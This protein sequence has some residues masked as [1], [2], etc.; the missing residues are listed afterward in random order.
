MSF[1][2]PEETTRQSAKEER[3][4]RDFVGEKK[5]KEI[6]MSSSLVDAAKTHYDRIQFARECDRTFREATGAAKNATARAMESA[7]GLV[8]GGGGRPVV[9]SGAGEEKSASTS[10]GRQREKDIFYRAKACERFDDLGGRGGL[11]QC[12]VVQPAHEENVLCVVDGKGRTMWKEEMSERHAERRGEDGKLRAGEVVDVGAY[13][14]R[15]TSEGEEDGPFEYS[16]DGEGKTTSSEYGSGESSSCFSSSDNDED[17]NR[18]KR[19]PPPPPEMVVELKVNEKSGRIQPPPGY[20]LVAKPEYDEF[21]IAIEHPGVEYEKQNWWQYFWGYAKVPKP[22]EVT[23]KQKGSGVLSSPK[24]SRRKNTPTAVAQ[25][26]KEK[27]DTETKI[28]KEKKEKTKWMR[29][30]WPGKSEGKPRPRPFTDEEVEQAR[31]ELLSKEAEA[32][33]TAA[34]LDTRAKLEAAKAAEAALEASKAALKV[35]E[36]ALANAKVQEA[37]MRAEQ[38][39][40]AVMMA[41][42][43]ERLAKVALVSTLPTHKDYDNAKYATRNVNL[44]TKEEFERLYG[45]EVNATNYPVLEAY[46]KAYEHQRLNTPS[47]ST[48]APYHTPEM[49]VSAATNNNVNNNNNNNKNNKN[50]NNAI[51]DSLKWLAKGGPLQQS[52]REHE[53]QKPNVTLPKVDPAVFMPVAHEFQKFMPP[54]AAVPVSTPVPPTVPEQHNQHQIHQIQREEEQEPVATIAT[55][56]QPPVKSEVDVVETEE[57]RKHKKPMKNESISSKKTSTPNG[58]KVVPTKTKREK[59]LSRKEKEKAHL[60]AK[61]A[62]LEEEAAKKRSVLKSVKNPEPIIEHR[63]EAFTVEKNKKPSTTAAGKDVAGAAVVQDPEKG[64][65]KE[66]SLVKSRAQFFA[67]QKRHNQHRVDGDDDDG[68]EPKKPL[69]TTEKAR[70]EIEAASAGLSVAD[71]AKRVANNFKP[72]AQR[73]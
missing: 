40:T 60:L 71:R 50:N 3:K 63:K 67:F 7:S 28:K 5:A 66:V 62:V 65:Q 46:R 51:V 53:Q 12:F 9:A 11:F 1:G 68:D 72:K 21:G 41:K 58:V 34:E 23:H 33:Q 16:T 70:L 31:L 29:D 8:S 10:L 52:E 25:D 24:S 4:R 64:T 30:G 39:R 44:A 32:R 18:M 43:A 36:A 13:Q 56:E 15:I 17:E 38:A 54:P 59:K 22:L 47:S 48:S 57:E 19:K 27:D 2:A 55:T 35:K 45:L 73:A 26:R 69:S 61:I 49:M 20:A 42:E 14:C 6:S 37:V